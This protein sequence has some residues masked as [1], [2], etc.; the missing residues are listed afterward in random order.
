MAGQGRTLPMERPIFPRHE[1]TTL[2]ESK[3]ISSTR[4]RA[5]GEVTSEDA[6]AG[7]ESLPRL[8]S[9]HGIPGMLILLK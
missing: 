1:A 8:D 4:H 7:Y 2:C 3:D 5:Q 9:Q 6:T